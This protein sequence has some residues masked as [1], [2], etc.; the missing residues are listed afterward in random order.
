MRR[1]LVAGPI[2]LCV[3]AVL[4]A[5]SQGASPAEEGIRGLVKQ[6]ESDLISIRRDL[7]AHPELGLREARTSERVA[8]YLRRV[9]LE[10]RTGI[11]TTG[12]LAVLKGA[13]P[14]PVV[15]MRA[16]MDALPITEETGLSYASQER[17]VLDGREVGLMHAC[18]H[19]IHTTVLLGVASV[20]ART[21]DDLAGTVLFV[22]QPG[23]ECCFGAERMIREGVFRDFKPEACFAFHV[24]DSLK[25]GRIGYTSGFASANVD[26]FEL[27][28]HSA[29]CHGASP[30]SCVDP[31]VVGARVVLDLQVML[32]REININRNA[33]ITV[34]SFRAGTAPNIVP[35]AARLSATVRTYGE[36]QRQLVKD[37][38]HRLIAGVCAASGATFDLNY[39]AGYPSL[40]ND[41]KLL[42]EVLATAGRVLGGP[43]ALVEQPPEMG[44]EDFS[45]FSKVAPSAMLSL[46][47]VPPDREQTSVHSPTFLPDEASISVGVELMANIIRDYLNRRARE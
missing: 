2:V 36:E 47:V 39:S 9:G 16:D 31:I 22:V 43:A 34:G 26:G 3:L 7:H 41:P 19:D 33:L 29:G 15:A 13:R 5:P 20:L 24:D 25:A 10:V 17:T 40:Y 23:E 35:Q 28:V 14:G 21:R 46:G 38:V 27:V 6:V 12:L 42:A 8:D 37:K 45:Y 1:S 30:W 4:A 11:A 44:G 18:G 32:A